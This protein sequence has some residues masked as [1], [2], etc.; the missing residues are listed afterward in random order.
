MMGH[1]G[2]IMAHG[3]ELRVY[4]RLQVP[5]LP[6]G[7]N[8]IGEGVLAIRESFPNAVFHH[9]PSRSMVFLAPGGSSIPAVSLSTHLIS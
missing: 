3:R 5:I 7:A 8:K 4:R 6:N 2:F 1:C 9:L